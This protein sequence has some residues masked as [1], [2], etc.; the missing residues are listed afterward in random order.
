MELYPRYLWYKQRINDKKLSEKAIDS[1]KI[2]RNK[3]PTKYQISN[4]FE[5]AKNIKKLMEF[6]VMLNNRYTE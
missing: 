3:F 5:S 6:Q 2:M 1:L 4:V